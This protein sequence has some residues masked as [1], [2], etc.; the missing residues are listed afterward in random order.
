MLNKYSDVNRPRFESTNNKVEYTYLCAPYLWSMLVSSTTINTL[1]DIDL[2]ISFWFDA[3]MVR[4]NPWSFHGLDVVILPF[5]GI[6][7]SERP[8]PVVDDQRG[9]Q[10][11][12][13]VLHPW[14]RIYRSGYHPSLRSPDYVTKCRPS[15][16]DWLSLWAMIRYGPTPSKISARNPAYYL[17]HR[18]RTTRL[19]DC[20]LMRSLYPHLLLILILDS[21][22]V[23]ARSKL[24][25][26][27]TH[28]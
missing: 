27:A 25:F 2:P 12:I 3:F 4:H 16:R 1:R 18:T 15:V 23:Y 13:H 22:R 5:M 17:T 24:L 14:V 21:W 6:T 10:F 20:H 28:S 26:Q 8:I 19:D 7:P 11:T 9:C